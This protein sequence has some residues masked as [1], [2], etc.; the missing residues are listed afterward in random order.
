MSIKRLAHK[1]VFLIVKVFVLLFLNLQKENGLTYS[2][3][4]MLIRPA[5]GVCELFRLKKLLLILFLRI[6]LQVD[7]LFLFT[8]RQCHVHICEFVSKTQNSIEL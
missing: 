3:Q 1:T 5:L 2:L 4:I 6:S 8:S 7:T